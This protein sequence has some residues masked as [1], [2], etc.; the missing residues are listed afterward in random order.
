MVGDSH[1]VIVVGA[2]LRSGAIP[3]R[4]MRN[5]MSGRGW[6]TLELVVGE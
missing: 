6:S 5:L 2:F 1:D 4:K 3:E